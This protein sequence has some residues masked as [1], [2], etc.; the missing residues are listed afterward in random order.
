MASF[1]DGPLPTRTIEATVGDQPVTI[2][3]PIHGALLAGE[4]R[5]AA[6]HRYQNTFNAHAGALADALLADGFEPDQAERTATRI[7]SV[8]MQI[9]IKLEDSE[10]RALIRH[11]SLVA[12]A[13]STLSEEFTSQQ[14]RKA[15]AVIRFRVKG[16]RSWSDED[17]EA[18][19]PQPVITALAAF[20]DQEQ[21]GG[22]PERTPEEIVEGM[23]DMLGKLAPSV[24][25]AVEV[26]ATES[27]GKTSSGEHE[28]S[29]P[30]IPALPPS[31]SPTPPSP[32][33]T[34]RS[35]KGSAA[36]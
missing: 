9:P 25:G 29:G 14:I 4:A 26:T 13:E 27:T 30:S 11:A 33:S 8:R 18:R 10:H 19:I 32:T 22:T 5:H 16:Q 35:S 15:T 28:P 7:L 17:T 6:Q 36:D 2:E 20:F 24:S 34:R 23:L 1:F 31:D 3:L 21:S 12:V